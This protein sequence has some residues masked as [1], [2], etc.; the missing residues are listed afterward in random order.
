[1]VGAVG[2]SMI[3]VKSSMIDAVGW[4]GSGGVGSGAVGGGSE[5]ALYI[6]FKGG[7]GGSGVG[8]TWVY[9]GVPRSVFEG[10][11]SSPSAGRTFLSSVRG[12]YE[13]AIGSVEE[14]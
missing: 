9:R 1:M 5:G 13:G 12:V 6:R 3:L 2:V 10:L 4:R 14:V 11:V 7:G 8:A